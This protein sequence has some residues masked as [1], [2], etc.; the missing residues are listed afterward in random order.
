MR[1]GNGLEDAI[2]ITK[3]SDKKTM[4]FEGKHLE[5]LFK[6]GKMEGILITVEPGEDFGKQYRHDGEELHFII[7]GEVEYMVG[8]N[9]YKMSEG[10]S[11]WHKSILPHGARNPGTKRAIYLTIG[12][13]P[14]F[15]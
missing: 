12:V 5:L 13:P 10:D 7:E 2:L 6:S 14:T 3:A 11:L 15:M 4:N 8:D 1:G 9:T